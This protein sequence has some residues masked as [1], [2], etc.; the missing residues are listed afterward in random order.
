MKQIKK[1]TAQ[2][3]RTIELLTSCPYCEWTN[4][5]SDDDELYERYNTEV[6]EK[7]LEDYEF[8]CVDCGKMFGL[9][10]IYKR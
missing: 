8:Q 3:E 5:I 7:E 2:W 4:T 6:G 1:T 10:K 9:T